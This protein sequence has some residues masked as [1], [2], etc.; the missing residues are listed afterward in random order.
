MKRLLFLLL[1]MALCF[2]AWANGEI[3]YTIW[4]GRVACDWNSPPFLLSDGGDE[5]LESGAE[6]GQ[7]LRFYLSAT[8]GPWRL[9]I[10]EGHFRATY[11]SFSS[12][13]S[14]FGKAIELS[15][16]GGYVSLVV[17]DAMLAHARVRQGWGGT[18]ACRGENLVVTRIAL[19]CSCSDEPG[20]MSALII[21]ELMQSNI[22]ATMDDHNEFPDSWVELYN[23][24]ECA[25]NLLA[26]RLG[27]SEN[28]D[29]AWQ[30]PATLIEGKGHR[31][32]YCDKAGRGMHTGFRLESG[33]GGS[34]YLFRAG[35]VVDCLTNLSKQPAPNV[36]YG[37]RT[38][39]EATWGY[40]AEP[41]PG[42][43][44]CGEL[45]SQLLPLPLF[46]EPGRVANDSMALLLRVTLPSEAPEGTML[47]YT[48]DGSEPVDTSTVFPATGLLV[49]TT[50]VLRVKPFCRGYLSPRSVTQSYIVHNREQSLPILSIVT[51]PRY[52][53]DSVMGI[54]V[55]GC[56]GDDRKNYEHDWRRPINLEFFEAGGQPSQLNQL[57]ETRIA[58]NATRIHPLKSL[59]VYA[60]KR[61]GEKRLACELFPDDRPG[62]TDYKSVLLRNAGNDFDHLYMRDAIMQRTLAWH[63]DLDHQA[64]R[65]AIL[66][67]NGQYRGLLNLRERSNDDNIHTNYD[68][69]EDIDMIEKWNYVMAGTNEAFCEFRDFYSQTGHTWDEYAERMDLIEY[70]N[71]MIL[72]LFFVN[73]DFPGNNIVMWRPR[74]EGG[75]WRFL[76]KDTDFGM[77]LYGR[78]VDF[79]MIE[80]MY[81]PDYYEPGYWANNEEYTRLFRHLMDDP[82]FAR[83]F[84]GRCAIYMGDF[85]NYE[86]IW[87]VWQPMYEAIREEIPHFHAAV[88]GWWPDY[89]DEVA[90]TQQWLRQRT[91]IFYQMLADYSTMGALRPLQVNTSLTTMEQEEVKVLFNGVELSA[92]R[93]DGMFYQGQQVMLSSESWAEGRGVTGWAWEMTTTDGEV[94]N[95]YIDGPTCVFTMPECTWCEVNAIVG[96]TP[97]FGTIS[98]DD[99][100]GPVAIY[101]LKGIRH[102]RLAKGYNIMKMGNGEARKVFFE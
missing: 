10:H 8:G 68:G 92:H 67:L 21:N 90:F 63:T 6:P 69:L 4:E 39:G 74:A 61:F 78:R 60:H 98:A 50:S 14:D 54:Y 3:E 97:G 101:D 89:D 59:A 31:L 25:V 57:C 40:Q 71:Y 20:G 16:A 13:D 32:V 73:I 85:L 30:L 7:E 9:T 76:T 94:I 91:E 48:T 83:E 12:T 87:A 15:S 49:D 86:G 82:R 22:D 52:L 44:N 18:F 75:R 96:D 46:S 35:S 11:A 102:Q 65:P 41:T 79:D 36:A 100:Q 26:Y 84:F 34:I 43:A 38:D 5:L 53:T 56:G 58:G 19:V 29:E 1:Q 95:R 77:G 45:C 62:V 55:D 28:P 23:P 72:Q 81:N 27:A 66:Y 93:F 24:N 80:Y 51:D 47:R 88:G 37:R 70:I 42:A 2:G 99:S 33:K 64:Y 17:T